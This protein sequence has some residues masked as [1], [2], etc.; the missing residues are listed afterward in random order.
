MTRMVLDASA[1]LALLNREAGAEVVAEALPEAVV[2][3]VN[4]SEVVA[5]LAD[6]GMPEHAVSEA[7]RGLA[8]ETLPFDLE[9]AYTTGLLTP[10]TKVVGLSLGDRCCLSLAR[11]LGVPALTADR[12]WERLSAGIEVRVIR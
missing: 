2:S 5:K 7:L 10:S 1:L 3:A 11:M 8:L 6:V 4:I 12:S 9:Q